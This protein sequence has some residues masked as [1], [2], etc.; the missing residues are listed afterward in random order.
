[1]AVVVYQY[2]VPFRCW[3]TGAGFF[4][5]KYLLN[6]YSNAKDARK[7]RRTLRTAGVGWVN[8]K[9]YQKVQKTRS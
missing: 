6:I 2:P 9:T 7:L 1:M 4:L 8:D 5:K 3:R